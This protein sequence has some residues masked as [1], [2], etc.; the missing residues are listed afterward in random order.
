MK[1]FSHRPVITLAEL[2][3]QL[4]LRHVDGER[5]P[6]REVYTGRVQYRLSVEVESTRGI[7]EMGGEIRRG[8]ED[9]LIERMSGRKTVRKTYTILPK[10]AKGVPEFVWGD[11]RGRSANAGRPP[12]RPAPLGPPPEGKS[13]VPPI[14]LTFSF[15]AFILSLRAARLCAAAAGLRGCEG[16]ELGGRKEGGIDLS[17]RERFLRPE[18]AALR[19]FACELRLA[20]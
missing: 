18:A 1:D 17:L 3:A 13:K 7:A 12:P 16:A 11:L 8:K 5:G 6:I 10:V 20:I 2:F 15:G 4:K 19:E 14:S 9:R